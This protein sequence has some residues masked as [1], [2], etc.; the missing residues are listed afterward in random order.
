MFHNSEKIAIEQEEMYFVY[1]AKNE[2]IPIS[3][4]FIQNSHTIQIISTFLLLIAYI[5]SHERGEKIST[6]IQTQYGNYE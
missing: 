5:Q 4:L 2:L 6:Q 1:W 3:D